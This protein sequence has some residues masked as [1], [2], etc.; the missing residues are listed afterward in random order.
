MN[1]DHLLED[2]P[3]GMLLCFV[4][5][6]LSVFRRVDSVQ[7]QFNYS[8]IPPHLET[9]SVDHLDDDSFPGLGIAEHEQ[10][11]GRHEERLKKISCHLTRS[12]KV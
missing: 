2:K 12:D 10:P 1:G 8:A 6:R 9:V 4:A 7:A 11:Y 3:L 5:V